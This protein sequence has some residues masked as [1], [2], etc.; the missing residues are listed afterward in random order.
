M[1]EWFEQSDEHRTSTTE[2]SMSKTTTTTENKYINGTYKTQYMNPRYWYDQAE[3]E[4]ATIERRVLCA[5]RIIEKSYEKVGDKAKTNV[6]AAIELLGELLPAF[7]AKA[8][9]DGIVAATASKA[10]DTA[11]LKAELSA[12][13]QREQELLARVAALE[14]AAGKTTTAPKA[15]GKRRTVS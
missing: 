15:G 3:D 5:A 11:K 4:S 8:T 9:K 2:A 13:A 10:A 1:F 12:A 7:E 14:A 6:A